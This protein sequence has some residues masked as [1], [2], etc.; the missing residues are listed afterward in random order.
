[1]LNMR[2]TP[3]NVGRRQPRPAKNR[4]RDHSTPCPRRLMRSASVSAAP[5]EMTEHLVGHAVTLASG[6]RHER[7]VDGC[8]S[9]DCRAC[10]AAREHHH[11]PALSPSRCARP[12]RS[13]PAGTVTERE[14]VVFGRPGPRR[15]PNGSNAAVVAVAVA[16]VA[17]EAVVAVLPATPEP[18]AP[19]TLGGASSDVEVNSE[20]RLGSA[21]AVA[22]AA[23]RA[24]RRVRRGRLRRFHHGAIAP[25]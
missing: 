15:L 10:C 3:Q 19:E 12:R 6:A 22:A 14:G 18:E 5:R 20:F 24:D 2:S 1:M 25:R 21:R 8:A 23:A 4:I 9:T 13:W 17:P 11:I 7:E 16:T